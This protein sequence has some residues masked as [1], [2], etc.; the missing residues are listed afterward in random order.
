[1][2]SVFLRTAQQESRTFKGKG[3]RANQR[4][5]VRTPLQYRTAGGAIK[6]AW[7]SGETLDMSVDGIF[8]DAPGAAPVGT[9]LELEIDWPGLY[10]GKPMAHLLVI[11]SVVRNDGR[12]TALRILSHQFRYVR[13]TVV[14]SRRGFRSW[15]GGRSTFIT[16]S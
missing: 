3:R 14:P 13:P 4:Y 1:M 15:T 8:I 7:K 16:I 12:G 11:G 10:H 2:T 6:A 9:K 5:T